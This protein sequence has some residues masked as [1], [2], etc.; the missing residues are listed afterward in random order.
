M[1]ERLVC[2][3]R[4]IYPG[5]DP[6]FGGKWSNMVEGKY[7]GFGS[8]YRAK[9]VF[10][11][12]VTEGVGAHPARGTLKYICYGSRHEYGEKRVYL[13]AE[14]YYMA[15]LGSLSVIRAIRGPLCYN[16]SLSIG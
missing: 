6:A 1:A 13:A 16:A 15:G 5:T 12:L 9:I 14:L 3:E 7:S 4:T 11:T 10:L 2:S 8:R